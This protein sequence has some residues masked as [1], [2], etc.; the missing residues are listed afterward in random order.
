MKRMKIPL[1]KSQLR[2]LFVSAEAAPFAK[3][4]GLG[5]VLRALPRAMRKL[6][7]DARVFVPKYAVI[8]EKEFP[9]KSVM[10]RLHIAS[11][12]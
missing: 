3:V 5:E 4:G 9:M 2:V 11:K 6:G 1:I 12:E 7:C 10:E 8:E